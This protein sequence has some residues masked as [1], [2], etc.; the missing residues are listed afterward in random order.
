M[1]RALFTEE[2]CFFDNLSLKH[3]LEDVFQ[4]DHANTGED[5]INV[6]LFIAQLLYQG[7]VP[8]S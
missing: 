5:G 6:I 1:G 4:S 7:D 2:V 8:S 3:L